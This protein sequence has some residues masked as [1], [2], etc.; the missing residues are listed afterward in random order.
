MNPIYGNPI[1][2]SFVDNPNWRNNLNS[3]SYSINGVY[4][5]EVL[6]EFE[7]TIP[8]Q[9]RMETVPYNYRGT[10]V[11][12]FSANGYADVVLTVYIQ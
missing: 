6:N 9:I 2:F 8:G 4:G 12:T 3:I 5:R 1:I 7:K 10:Q 11:W